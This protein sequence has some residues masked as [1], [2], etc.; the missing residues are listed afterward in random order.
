MATLQQLQEQARQQVQEKLEEA[1]IRAQKALLSNDKLLDAQVK[2]ALLA[3]TTNKL[4][5]LDNQCEALVESMPVYS[6]VTREQRKWNP[7]RV[8]GYGNHI[9]LLTGLLTGIQYSIKEHREQLLA[10]TGLTEDLVEQ[11]LEA[12]GRQAYYS[13]VQHEVVQAQPYNLEALLSWLSVI[14]VTLGIVLDKTKLTETNMD[15]QF[16]IAENK[17]IQQQAEAEEAL[18]LHQ[19]AINI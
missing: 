11:T 18:L 9:A 14:E 2:L 10:L 15:I 19:Q 17:A 1:K 16:R 12:F 3:E 8:Y 13:K 6:S 4:T 5:E 7:S